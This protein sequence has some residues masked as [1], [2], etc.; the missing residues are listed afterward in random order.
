MQDAL[1]TY[2]TGK[3]SIIIPVYNREQLL[4][5]TLDSILAQTYVN[6]ECI[7]VDDGSTDASLSV[8][9]DYAQQ[10]S[11]FKVFSRPAS[12]KKGANGCRNYGF[13]HAIGEFIQWFDSDDLMEPDLLNSAIKFMNNDVDIV[14][15]KAKRF[16]DLNDI[17]LETAFNNDSLTRYSIY[18]ILNGDDLFLTSQVLIKYIFIFNSDHLFDEN[19]K[20]NQE[21]EYFTR[22][23][24]KNPIVRKNEKS[25]ILI[26]EHSHSIT[27]VY[28]SANEFERLKM[29]FPAY[30][31]IYFNCKKEGALT[32]EL[33]SILDDY[34][35]RCLRKMPSKSIEYIQLYFWGILN[36]WFPSP[37][38]ASKIFISRLVNYA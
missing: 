13:Y 25:N 32:I 27:S 14:I 29:N 10:D 16:R 33:K 24:L 9:N 4:S 21:T 36:S 34:F 38:M 7:L 11:R 20:R 8:C 30:S 31:T 22:L 28:K 1:K 35:Y 17:G 15:T 37:I 5:E 6:W 19:L 2:H 23:L 26:R 3:V 18:K 12:V